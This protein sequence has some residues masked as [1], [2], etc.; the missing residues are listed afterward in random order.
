M[1]KGLHLLLTGPQT[2]CP[3][4][5]LEVHEKPGQP[6]RLPIKTNMLKRDHYIMNALRLYH[7]MGHSIVD[8]CKTKRF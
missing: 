1:L 5:T 3:K 4:D 8:I 6:F 7:G 2:S